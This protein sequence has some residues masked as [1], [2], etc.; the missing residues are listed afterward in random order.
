MSA[1]ARSRH[2]RTA[3][4]LAAAALGAASA[5][6]AHEAAGPARCERLPVLQAWLERHAASWDRVLGAEPGYERPASF[7]VCRLDGPRPYADNRANRVFVRR[8]QTT[9]DQVTLAHEYLHLAFQHYPSGHDER[10]V[11]TQARRL[12]ADYP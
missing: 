7:E 1:R 12:I 8:L 2:P 6:H 10:Y 3:L 11:E 4:A 5:C 9:D